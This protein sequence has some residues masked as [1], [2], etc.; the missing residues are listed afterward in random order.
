[1]ILWAKGKSGGVSET[2][3]CGLQRERGDLVSWVEGEYYL[4]EYRGGSHFM[5]EI[6]LEICKSAAH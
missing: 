3:F 1:M 5:E 6:H 2:S 4:R